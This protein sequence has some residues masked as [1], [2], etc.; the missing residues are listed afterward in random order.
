MRPQ[1]LYSKNVMLLRYTRR[2][3][4]RKR[5]VEASVVV[6]AILLCDVGLTTVAGVKTRERGRV[7]CSS[8]VEIM[9]ASVR[10]S[11]P[12]SPPSS[13]LHSAGSPARRGGVHCGGGVRKSVVVPDKCCTKRLGHGIVFAEA[14]AIS[15][16]QRYSGVGKSLQSLI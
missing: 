4:R 13:S 16:V 10:L 6:V 14:E 9:Q 5:S 12:Y 3:I 7:H 11:M 15:A 8:Q 1:S 2:H